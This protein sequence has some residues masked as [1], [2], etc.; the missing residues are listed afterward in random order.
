MKVGLSPSWAILLGEIF[1]W[2]GMLLGGK[3]GPF[4][5]LP[6]TK[7]LNLSSSYYGQFVNTF[8]VH[9]EYFARTQFFLIGY[10][11]PLREGRD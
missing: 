9:W 8:Y 10:I 7:Y 6:Y 5:S 1:L 2:G 3:S 11:T 4:A